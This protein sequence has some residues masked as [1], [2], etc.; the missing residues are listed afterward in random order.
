MSERTWENRP[1]VIRARHRSRAVDV[2]L[3]VIDGY[4]FHLTGRNAA[5]IA[6]YAFI[7]VFPLFLVFTTILGFILQDRP[8]LQAEIVDSALAQLPIIGDT[9]TNRPEALRGSAVALVVGLSIALWSGMKAFVAVQ[10]SLD[11]IAEVPVRDR[12]SFLSM[13]VRALLGI[14]VVGGAQVASTAITVIASQVDSAMINRV[15]LVVGAAVVNSAVVACS[16]RFLSSAPAPWATVW[17]G[18]TTS[19]IAFAILQLVGTT[20][21]SRSIANAESVYGSFAAVIAILAWLS[22]HAVVVL[23]GAEL[24]RAMIATRR[25]GWEPERTPTDPPTTAAG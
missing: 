22:L 13:R 18:A 16:Y 14:A 10:R 23:V 9:L 17:P 5:V 1:R 21:V 2:L 12:A 3:R 19:G 7:S 4:R 8:D 11:D 15:L 20:V 6:H 24:N 25:D